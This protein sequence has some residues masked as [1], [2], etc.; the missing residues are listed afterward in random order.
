[1]RYSIIRLLL[2]NLRQKGILMD[3]I[4]LKTNDRSDDLINELVSVWEKSVSA[5]H[6][7]LTEKDITEIRE[8]VAPAFKMI[9]VL[10]VAIDDDKVIGF[11]GIYEN[12]LE[13]LF[14]DPAYFGQGMGYKLINYCFEQYNIQF[15][16]VNEQNPRAFKFY[17]RQGFSVIE[18]S[19]LDS[20]G[21]P[22]PI[23][24]M[25]KK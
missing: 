6:F 15:V 18:R 8:Q 22:F 2:N 5:S 10:L 13:M 11:A 19:P 1:M 24:H 4:D 20:D 9:P 3:I 21:R 17:Q 7:F 23:L 14:V 16:D 12:K 25:Q